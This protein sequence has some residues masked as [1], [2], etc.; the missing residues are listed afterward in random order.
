MSRFSGTSPSSYPIMDHAAA[1]LPGM[2]AHLDMDAANSLPQGSSTS[3]GRSASSDSS[4]TSASSSMSSQLLSPGSSCTELSTPTMPNFS[5][6]AM[7]P[8]EPTIVS[9][10]SAPP[11]FAMDNITSENVMTDAAFCMTAVPL[12]DVYAPLESSFLRDPF[13]MPPSQPL[14]Y[15]GL[16]GSSNSLRNIGLKMVGM[17][18]DPFLMSQSLPS[19][20]LPVGKPSSL[21]AGTLFGSLFEPRFSQESQSQPS[22]SFENLLRINPQPST[23][24]SASGEVDIVEPVLSPSSAMEPEAASLSLLADGAHV[25]VDTE[26]SQCASLHLDQ[27]IAKHAHAVSSRGAAHSIA[28]TS[29]PFALVVELIGSQ[30]GLTGRGQELPKLLSRLQLHGKLDAQTE[31]SKGLVFDAAIN[32]DTMG[33]NMLPTT[34]QLLYPHR[35]FID[36]CLPWPAVRTRLLKH[37]LT[38]PVCEE[39]FALDLLLSIL[40]PDEALS[41]AR[42]YGD[43]VLDPEA[44]ELSERM[45]TKWWGLF[46]DSIIR[47]T[48][49]WR[50]Q[51]GLG[52]LVYP[53]STYAGN[54]SVRQGL[55]TGSLDEVY[56]LATTHLP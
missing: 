33:S 24:S 52:C 40:S 32:W 47:R 38:N 13:A 18:A 29:R 53:Q 1:T 45:W 50:R 44:W 4:S 55:G 41:S 51:R 16:A 14:T 15:P 9:N 20:A 8:T 43:D 28:I 6:K 21:P 2:P 49:W 36:A 22:A 11:I 48:N 26:A 35:A 30:F 19:P 12:S 31:T 7:R 25:S 46:D 34:E 42:V 17:H 54:D 27:V 56:R 3:R 37:A 10:L 5:S 39:E 23:H